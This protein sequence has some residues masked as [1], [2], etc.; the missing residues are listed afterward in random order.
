MEGARAA[1]REARAE[2]EAGQIS[3]PEYK[4]TEASLVTIINA[5]R[6]SDPPKNLAELSKVSHTELTSVPPSGMPGDLTHESPTGYM[7]PAHEEEFLS[8]LDN[9]IANA[10]TDSQ[11]ILPRPK[12]PNEKEREKE[13]QLHNPVS[14][15]NWLRAHSDLKPITHD[16]E[17]DIIASHSNTSEPS[18]PKTK[19]SPK[20]PSSTSNTS[21]KPSRKRASSALLAKQ[22]PEEELLDDEG[23]V[24][25]GGSE[26]PVSKG[27]RKRDGDNAYRPKGGSS[28]SRK[29]TK[30]SSGSA[31]RKLEPEVEEEEVDDID[32]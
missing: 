26:V 23:F 20:P 29:R 28:K 16:L 24:I 15:Y 14:V 27:K 31:V 3:L 12:K 19:P 5:P 13:A 11:P 22:E 30:G 18:A 6:P 8:T 25:G 7:S 4:D 1:L 9:Y 17:K 21:T 2:Y 32:T 10:Q